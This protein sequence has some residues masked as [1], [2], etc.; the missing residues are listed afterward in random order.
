M[1]FIH[2]ELASLLLRHPA[3]KALVIYGPIGTGK[4]T[5]L[6]AAPLSK[7]ARW[8]QGNMS[9]DRDA[10]QLPSS[11]NIQNLLDST[12]T[13]VIEDAQ[14]IPDIGLTLKR[15]VDQNQWR[16]KPIRILVSAAQDLMFAP[17]IK[18]SAVGRLIPLHLWSLTLSELAAQQSWKQIQKNITNRVL[19]GA[20]PSVALAP[21]SEPKTLATILETLLP[22][23]CALLIPIPR[24]KAISLLQS[25]AKNIG[26]EI[27]Y[28][29]LAQENGLSEDD[30][31]ESIWLLERAFLIKTCSA[32]MPK[33]PRHWDTGKK[34]YFVDTGVRNAL[35]N[36][37]S[38]LDN[39]AD[40]AAL[41]ENFVFME[42]IKLHDARANFASMN[43]LRD[44]KGIPV[45]GVLMEKEEQ[46]QHTFMCRWDTNGM[47]VNSLKDSAYLATPDNIEAWASDI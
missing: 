44:E 47:H 30:V 8:F 45:P 9:R 34:L 21:Q 39:R 16:D 2:R 12:D 33:F 38:P 15:L 24:V 23:L 36:D 37:F 22:E 42:R 20:L 28:N 1:T 31:A 10:L 7:N 14:R 11:A 35:L 27:H 46:H 41:W 43:Y 40:I 18:E 26:Q 5:L 25:L 6:K 29:L 3:G 17:G 32:F 13:L 4:T 19:Y